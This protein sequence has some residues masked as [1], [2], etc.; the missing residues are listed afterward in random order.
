MATAKLVD[1]ASRRHVNSVSRRGA[2]CAVY[3][4]EAH[5]IV[6]LLLPAAAGTPREAPDINV[7]LSDQQTTPQE[8]PAPP[9]VERLR[10]IGG[11]RVGAH[12]GSGGGPSTP[13][14]SSK[15]EPPPAAAGSAILAPV[16]AFEIPVANHSYPGGITSSDGTSEQAGADGEG[17]G[18]FADLSR[19]ARL[20]GKKHWTCT[21]E[22]PGHA[23]VSVRVLVRPDGSARRVE[24]LRDDTVA[25][26]ILDGARPCAM[27][28]R[29]IPGTDRD[30]RPATRWTLPFRIV[31]VGVDSMH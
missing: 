25:D 12:K 13:R 22:A 14:P 15:H 30:G 31:V 1:G 10:P 11:H 20:G 28:E 8:P 23:S 24:V 16:A 7:E 9:P 27:I 3:A 6:C 26:A 29:Y 5:A 21:T 4:V 19:P 18:G 17:G 2:W